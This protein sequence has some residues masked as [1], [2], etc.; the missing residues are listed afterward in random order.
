MKIFWS[1]LRV[2][3]CRWTDIAPFYVCVHA[4]VCRVSMRGKR[5]CQGFEKV[6]HIEKL[7]A[8]ACNIYTYTCLH[9][10]KL[11]TCKWG[12]G[13]ATK[14][15]LL[16]KWCILSC[17]NGQT[18]H[19][20]LPV[21]LIHWLS[22]E[23]GTPATTLW[24]LHLLWTQWCGSIHSPG[25]ILIR[26]RSVTMCVFTLCICACAWWYESIHSP[27][28]TLIWH[29]WCEGTHVYVHVSKDMVLL[30]HPLATTRLDTIQMCADACY[31]PKFWCACLYSYL[32]GLYC[33][34]IL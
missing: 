3:I 1:S 30:E 5:V 27:Q 20:W 18:W 29:T 23:H 2:S 4:C 24:L 8:S 26:C 21:R 22:C 33:A 7:C 32:Q 17:G 19:W 28:P 11:L 31:V 34:C 9:T 6:V 15:L 16:R 10:Q 25:H 13:V 14:M 12:A